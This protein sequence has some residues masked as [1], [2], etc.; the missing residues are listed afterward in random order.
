VRIAVVAGLG[1]LFPVVPVLAVNAAAA[2]HVV[3]F[4]ENGGM[5]FFQ[6]HCPANSITTGNRFAGIYALGSPVAIQNDRG[7][8]YVFPTHPAWDQSYF[9][10]EGIRCIKQDPVGQ[11]GVIARNVADLGITSVPWPQSG[12]RGLRR[13]VRPANLIYSVVLPISLVTSFFLLIQG[14]PRRY[15][16]GEWI[17]IATV[18]AVLPTAVIFYGDPRFRVPYDVFGL[19]LTGSVISEWLDRRAVR[20]GMISD[21]S[22]G[23]GPEEAQ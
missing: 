3:G 11:I 20:K 19:A 15:R 12:D 13:F 8:D 21:P 17:L 9:I 14:P 5:N 16:E 23:V 18:L 6:G 1:L 7:I 22:A 2:G 10:R 4:S